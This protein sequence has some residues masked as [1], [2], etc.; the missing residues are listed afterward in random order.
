MTYEEKEEELGPVVDAI[1]E[2]RVK[3][4]RKENPERERQ[5]NRKYRNE[6]RDKVGQYSKKYT[7]N[8]P[9]KVNALTAKRRA[10]KKNQTPPWADMED[11]KQF[12]INVPEN[13]HIDHIIPLSKGGYHSIEN[14]QY[15][16]TSDNLK[17]SDSW[18]YTIENNTWRD[19]NG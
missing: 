19:G 13:C 6:N 7:M 9:G 15:L 12:Y 2:K 3:E 5:R 1:A 8:N 4:W 10:L 17:K 16:T 11:I 18:D 14:L